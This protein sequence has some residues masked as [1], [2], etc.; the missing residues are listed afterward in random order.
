[1]L[2]R[3]ANW[4]SILLLSL[5]TSTLSSHAADDNLTSI[6]EAGRCAIRGHCGSDSLLGPQLPCPDNG[7]AESPADDVRKKLVDICG[8]KWKETDVCCLDEQLDA[9]QSN[10]KRADPLISSCPACKSNF[11]NLFCEFTCS[12]DQSLFVNVTKT[13][14]KS[15]KLLVTELDHLVS[16]EYGS[17][18]YDSC[19]EVK[20]GSTNGRAMDFIGGGAKNYTRFL[21]FLG[22]KKFLGSPFQMNFP[23][24]DEDGF[25]GMKPMNDAA[26]PCNDTDERYRCTCVD[27]PGSCVDLPEIQE[28]KQCY[29]GL[30]PCLSFSVI[31]VYSAFLLLLVL[32]VSGHVAYQKHTRSKNERLRLLQDAAPSDDEDEGDVVHA[33]G[34]LD[35]PQRRY[36]PNEVFDGAFSQLGRFCARFPGITIGVSIVV[37]LLLSLG[38]VSFAVETDPVRLWV[39]P[40]S[41]AAQEKQFFDDNFGPFFRAEQVFL[42]ND[43]AESGPGPIL[44]YDTLR[45]WFDVE[46][47]VERLRVADSITLDQVCYK[48]IGDA[49]VIQSVTG[50]F[51]GDVRGLDPD[52]WEDRLKACAGNPSDCLAPS[53]QPLDPKM[54]FGGYNESILESKALVITWVVQ[55]Y[56]EGTKGLNRAMTWED[57]LKRTLLDVQCEATDRGLRL[58]F[59]TEISLEQ[60]LNKSTNTDAKIVVISY[61]IMFLYASLALGSTTITFNSLVRNPSTALVQS[62]F[63][64]GIVGILIVLMSVSSSVGLFSAA[65]IKVTL[66]IAEVIPFLV[67]AVGV[68]NIF[69]IVHEFERVNALNPDLTIEQRMSKALGR[70][71]PSILLSATTETFA[72]ALG[73]AVGMPAVRNFAAYA[74]GAVF[75][76]AL[77]QV[78]MFISVLALNQQ[79]VEDGRADCFPCFQVSPGESLGSANGSYGSFIGDDEGGLQRFIRK[80]YAPALLGKKTKVAIIT[81]FLGL[82]CAGLGLLPQVQLGLDQRIA[83]PSDSYL[84]QYFNDLDDY[85]GVGPPVYFVVKELNVTQR[86]HQL[87]LCGQF[88][89]CDSYSLANIL[90][91]E[92][93]RSELSYIADPAASWVDNFFQWLNPEYKE[94][95]VEKNK[96]CLID[97]IP[98]WNIALYG[99][100]EGEEFNDYLAKWLKSKSTQDC[101]VAA[102]AYADA[103]VPDYDRTTILASHFR[104]SHTPLR[105]QKDFIAAYRSARRISKEIESYQSRSDDEGQGLTVFPYSKFYIF[106]DQY[107]S[108]IPLSA[109]LLGSALAL[110]LLLTTVLLGSLRTALVVTAT[111]AMTLIDIIGAM[112][113][114]HVS[115]N[116]VSLVNLIISVGI[117]LEFCAH[118]ARAFT[119]PSIPIMERVPRLRFRGRDARVWTA[120]VNVGASVF[121][122]ITIT[123]LLGV[124]VLAF[125]RSKIF[126][127]YYFRVWVA[128]IV[129]AATHA[130]VF[131]PVAL[132][133]FGGQGTC[134]LYSELR[135]SIGGALYEDVPEGPGHDSGDEAD[136]EENEDEEEEEISDTGDSDSGE[137]MIFYFRGYDGDGETVLGDGDSGTTIAFL[138]ANGNTLSRE[139]NTN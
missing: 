89:T 105:S 99:M 133:V 12:P 68:D 66:I 125:T 54:L 59:N 100:P 25:P 17:T 115:L 127:I 55:N 107:L 48:P 40:N 121:S 24:P 91:Q 77:L 124:A 88:S 32:A 50:Y 96:P 38:W 92:R 2:L 126:E 22:E 65:G 19:K 26:H 119:V 71:G 16:D 20:F 73:A 118:I 84:I 90:E 14:E 85:F 39:A 42:I 53:G 87:Q 72:F 109:A 76:N 56:A 7:K 6:H 11:V 57:E 134:S 52:S 103:V 45:W 83:I 49:C 116:A 9:L 137:T 63:M 34:I 80:I 60:E 13:K 129:F 117:S 106:F 82:F 102:S 35:K 64:L 86:E 70:M 101:P 135:E 47:R 37:V 81:I 110:I 41:D 113:L 30:L 74:A 139:Q 95:C 43:T 28:G 21:D 112:A 132:S 3:G 67:L 104:T 5:T 23:R 131:L 18:F 93:K 94:C 69:L 27:C 10:L 8:E 1:M 4:R 44:S 128:L 75:I 123:K 98:P 79:R 97:R 130:L 136:V 58:S 31:I 62:K 61:I 33:A 108:I 120:L 138:P 78:T 51:G 15:G 114:F 36:Y 111:V 29:V 46:A 122:G